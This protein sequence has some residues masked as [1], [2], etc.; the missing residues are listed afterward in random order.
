MTWNK[1][2]K[3]FEKETKPKKKEWKDYV[4]DLWNKKRK[5]WTRHVYPYIPISLKVGI[6]SFVFISVSTCAIESLKK[7]FFE[8]VMSGVK[9]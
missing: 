4:R 5:T 8:I 6:V 2:K 1:R 7:C 9:N 3:S